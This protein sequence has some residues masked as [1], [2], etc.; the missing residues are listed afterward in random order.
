MRII[1]SPIRWGSL[2]FISRHRI[3]HVGPDRLGTNA[4]ATQEF[5][6]NPQPGATQIRSAI[7]L[8]AVPIQKLFRQVRAN[9]L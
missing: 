9:A 1:G 4:V 3:R 7:I 6:C 5:E 8:L 2:A